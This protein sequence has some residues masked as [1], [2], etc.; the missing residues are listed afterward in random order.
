M[1]SS[2]QAISKALDLALFKDPIYVNISIGLSLSLNAD[3]IFIPLMPMLLANMGFTASDVTQMMTIFFASD[4]ACRIMLSV[5][6]AITTLQNRLL[7]LGGAF[8]SAVFRIGK[9]SYLHERVIK[10]DSV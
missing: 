5:L 9:F 6:S 3:Q 10:F 8:F 4:L 2:R 7:L 1:F